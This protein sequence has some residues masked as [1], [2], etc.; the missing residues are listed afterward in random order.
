M[1]ALK[2][3]LVGGLIAGALDI[4]Y[5]CVVYGLKFD[6]PPSRIFQSVAAGWIGR[7][8]AR[9]G[10]L[11]TVLLGAVSHFSIAILM[12][13]AYVIVSRWLPILLKRPLIMGALYGVLLFAIMNYIVVP[14]SARHGEPPTQIDEAFLIA[15]FPHVALVGPA[16]ALAARR[17]LEP[18]AAA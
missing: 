2:A 11:P 9:A 13:A 16:I 5:A 3:I 10:G 14:Y 4:T 15:L 12:A 18:Q 7:D 6:L 1:K 8:A 17:F